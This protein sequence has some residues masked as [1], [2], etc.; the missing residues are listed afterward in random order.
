M[1]PAMII[2]AFVFGFA[3]YTTANR[4]RHEHG[5]T[6]WGWPPVLWGLAWFAS[7]LLGG[8]LFVLAASRTKKSLARATLSA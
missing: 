8:L 5:R 6:P 2:L 4:F 3:G 7:L 1:N